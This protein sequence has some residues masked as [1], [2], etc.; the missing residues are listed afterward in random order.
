MVFDAIGSGDF[1]AVSDIAV[2]PT[3]DGY[4]VAGLVWNDLALG[5]VGFN[6]RYMDLGRERVSGYWHR[7][8]R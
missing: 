2:I 4:L 5:Y 7:K 1:G 8:P 3:A 6:H